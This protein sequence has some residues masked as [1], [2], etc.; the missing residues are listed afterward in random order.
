MK[1]K[2]VFVILLFIISFLESEMITTNDAVFSTRF[3]REVVNDIAILSNNMIRPYVGN[4][5]SQNY[6]NKDNSF[7]IKTKKI[8]KIITKDKKF[9]LSKISQKKIIINISHKDER[10]F[11]SEN[12]NRLGL[13]RHCLF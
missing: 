7:F 11:E 10:H 3:E 8:K 13:W 6:I 5:S 9:P 2:I 1:A 4:S 12:I